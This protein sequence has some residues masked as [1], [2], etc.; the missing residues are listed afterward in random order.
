MLFFEKK[1]DDSEVFL[2][3]KTGIFGF[4]GAVP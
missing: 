1:G 4:F 3:E 2:T